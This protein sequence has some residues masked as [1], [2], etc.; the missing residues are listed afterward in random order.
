MKTDIKPEDLA[1]IIYTSGTTGNPKGVMLSHN[2]IISQVNSTSKLFPLKSGQDV[3][4]SCLP[5]AHIFELMVMLYYVS[6]GVFIYFADDIKNLGSLMKKIQ[7][8]IMTAVPRLLEKVFVKIKKLAEEKSI[9]KKLLLKTAIRRAVNKKTNLK[10]NFFDKILDKIIYKKFRQIFGNR[11]KLLI[12]GGASLSNE[13]E[14][15]YRNIN[16]N[17]FCGYG[18]TETSAVVAVNYENNYR[19][20]TVGKNFPGI[21]LK[22]DEKQ[23][24][25]VKGKNV[26]IG[27]HNLNQETQE[28]IQDGWFKTGDLATIDNEGF[29]KITGRKKEL[30]KNSNGKYVSPVPIENKLTQEIDFLIGAIVIAEN[31]RFTSAI[32]FA[33]FDLI[34]TVKE[35]FFF[36]GTK[37]EFLSSKILY[38]FIDKKILHLNQ[39]LNHWES[40]QKFY[41]AKEEISIESGEI[42][43]SMKLKRG[44][45][46]R[47]YQKIIDD[48]YQ[49]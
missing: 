10:P 12:C 34:E 8:T 41:I 46:E 26:M 35:K 49:E 29:V 27:Y 15:F 38:D 4:L 9:I 42:T 48:F 16:I 43:P 17:L 14:A 5:L 22:I 28:V 3:A 36:K 37:Q 1:T 45:L 31:R 2:N 30:F 40:I 6:Q 33:D 19:F 11:I 20:G 32:L 18:L 39:N 21:E 24:L 7:P 44:L 25:L 47:K 13:V 23:E